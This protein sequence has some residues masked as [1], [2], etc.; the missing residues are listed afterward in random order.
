MNLLSTKKV[1]KNKS[2]CDN[3]NYIYQYVLFFQYGLNLVIFLI[4]VAF[5]QSIQRF[6]R[7]LLSALGENCCRING[8]YMNIFFV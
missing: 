7:S 8:S 3:F 5:H 6:R 2:N 1:L 4:K